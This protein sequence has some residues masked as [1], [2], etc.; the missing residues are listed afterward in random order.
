M[1]VY[2][3]FYLFLDSYILARAKAKKAEY[4][5]DLSTNDSS[6]QEDY[7]MRSSRDKKN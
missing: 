3:I 4:T 7:K 1:F 2:I 6:C 5:S